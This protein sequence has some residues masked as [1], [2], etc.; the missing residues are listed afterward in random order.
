MS[1]LSEEGEQQGELARP[2]DNEV[3]QG[4]EVVL[5][6]GS[7]L[8]INDMEQEVS[9]SSSNSD[10]DG[11]LISSDYP[12]VKEVLEENSIFLVF[13]LGFVFKFMP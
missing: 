10:S 7:E 4:L 13:I 12:T 2:N 5:S 8:E 6:R 9:M 3:V 1:Q 11:I